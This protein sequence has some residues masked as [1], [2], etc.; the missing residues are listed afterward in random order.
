MQAP[1]QGGQP[2]GTMAVQQPMPGGKHAHFEPGPWRESFCGC[3]SDIPTC[4]MACCCPCIQYG[5]NYEAIHQDGG[6]LVQGL[7]YFVLQH[8]CLHCVIHTGFRGK[9]REKFNIPGAQHMDCLLTCCC[10]C[11]A[12]A[13]EAREI[14]H[15]RHEAAAKGI[16]W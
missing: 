11:C 8:M 6:C 7:I 15:R 1:A 3:C 12:I 5:Q 4:L 14:Q 13:Q 2:M 9:V 16:N 10:S